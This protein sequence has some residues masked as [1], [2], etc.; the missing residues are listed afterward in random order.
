MIN[1][2]QVILLSLALIAIGLIIL[3]YRQGRIGTPA[4]LF[5]LLLWIVAAVVILFPHSTVGVAHFLGIG[6]GAD[7]VLYLGAIL[8]LY[9]IFRLFVRLEQ[10]NREITKIVRSVALREAGLDR[11]KGSRGG[12]APPAPNAAQQSGRLDAGH[13]QNT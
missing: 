10:M 13:G 5:W 1:D 9:L 6:R 3:R 11:L 7:L 8:I 12:D 4:F 2:A